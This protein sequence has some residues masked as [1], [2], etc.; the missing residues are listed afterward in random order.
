MD[1]K[2][3][4]GRRSGR[5]KIPASKSYAHRL[6]ICSAFADNETTISCDG[7]SK[8]IAATIDCLRALGAGITVE[9]GKYIKVI[10]V[11][12]DRTGG[13]AKKTDTEERILHCGESGSTLRFLIPVVGA[14][15]VDAVFHMEGRLPERP[16]DAF[17]SEL[18]KHGMKIVQDKEKLHCSGQ[19]E[20]GTY[21]IPGNISSQ[22]VSG[23]L[24]ALPLLKAESTLDITGDIQSRRYIDMTEEILESM[25]AEFEGN[26][27]SYDIRPSVL[28]SK[29][30]VT[31]ESDWSNAA[32]FM[33][34]GA[35]S[36]KGIELSGMNPGSKQGDRAIV[37]ILKGFGA[38]IEI[39]SDVLTVK[40]GSL[41]GQ[42]IDASEIPDLVPTICALAA[43]AEGKTE[44]VNAGRL[45]F[46]ESDRLATTAGLINDLGGNVSETAEGLIITGV[47]S[48]KGG[49]VDSANDHRIA[50]AA[51]VAACGSSKD[52]TVKCAECVAKSYP[53]FWEDLESLEVTDEQ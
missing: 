20:A 15:G 13:V 9:D 11:S 41:K 42:V 14:V 23:L 36:D 40:R 28:R 16:L 34:M 30:D 22:F 53:A 19:L 48:L 18:E 38:R 4:C 10:P 21:T 6:L 5:I 27:S 3:A 1:R 24:F 44:I 17:K 7:M 12:I 33:C 29:G 51:A 39:G 49:T 25:G 35:M 52:V 46:K 31:V 26:E 2:V 43:V 8:D 37:D 50:M 32:F 47:G 45:R